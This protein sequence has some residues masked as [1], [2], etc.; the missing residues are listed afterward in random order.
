MIDLTSHD[1]DNL[2]D[3]EGQVPD[4]SKN[5]NVTEEDDGD[6]NLFQIVRFLFMTML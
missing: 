3:V 1:G 5:N 2:R 4:D 6:V